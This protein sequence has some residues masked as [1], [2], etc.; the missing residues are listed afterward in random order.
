MID[1][2][3]PELER[4][5]AAIGGRYL[6]VKEIRLPF[7]GREVLYHVGCAVVDTT[8][9]GAGGVAFARVAGFVGAWRYRQAADGRP[10]SRVE[11]IAGQ[12][13]RAQIARR[14]TQAEA[15][16]QVSFVD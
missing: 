2:E 8:C 10:V 11:P 12:R 3:H 1:Y 15:V 6:F 13:A 7:E 14:V 5:V 16:H 9:C 4:E